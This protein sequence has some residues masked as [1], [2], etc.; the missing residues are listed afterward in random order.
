MKVLSVSAHIAD[1]LI[2]CGGIMMQLMAQGHEVK[3]VY[4]SDM[5]RDAIPTVME[6]LGVRDFET[7]DFPINAQEDRFA[8][9][10][11]KLSPIVADTA[12]D[13]TLTLWPSEQVL[14][15]HCMTGRATQEA[16]LNAFGMESE[17]RLYFF[18]VTQYVPDFH[19]EIYV[20]LSEE[21]WQ[22]KAD[23]ISRMDAYNEREKELI[24]EEME[25]RALQHG[26]ECAAASSYA[27]A[28]APFRPMIIPV[29]SL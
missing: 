11:D 24:L 28:L 14:S 10:Q 15:D 2:G 5:K 26:A 17:N 19:P 27:E 1:G 20:E 6:H 16:F 21:Q 29:D 8:E 12:P 7:L 23:C 13:V 4:T 25:L 18:E 3:V 9:L 22:K